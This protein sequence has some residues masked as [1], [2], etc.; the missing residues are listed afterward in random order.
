MHIVN[1][2]VANKPHKR[3]TEELK[4]GRT[5]RTILRQ[6]MY[7]WA[8]NPKGLVSAIPQSIAIEQGIVEVSLNND[9]IL[10]MDL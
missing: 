8:F 9:M 5:T 10:E 3:G 1:S 7:G 4:Y 6:L 2:G